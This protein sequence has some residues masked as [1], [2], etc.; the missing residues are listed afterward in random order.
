MI[1]TT[2]LASNAFRID[3]TYRR[4]EIV[5]K[6]D[7]FYETAAGSFVAIVPPHAAPFLAVA[8]EFSGIPGASKFRCF[9]LGRAD[10]APSEKKATP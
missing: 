1:D 8:F 6:S 5:S 10:R 7:R 3:R 2:K 4:R 9:G